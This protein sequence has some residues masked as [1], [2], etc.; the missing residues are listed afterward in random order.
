[1]TTATVNQSD[2]QD[3]TPASEEG[4]IVASAG[5]NRGH[6]IRSPRAVNTEDSLA[7]GA[8]SIRQTDLDQAYVPNRPVEFALQDE[9]GKTRKISLPPVSF[10][11]QNLVG[12]NRP[13]DVKY[14]ETS[15]VW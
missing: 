6:R 7:R 2:K 8:D 4:T 13:T 11:A 14:T 5:S 3:G 15:R 12:S 10:G 1:K 9:R